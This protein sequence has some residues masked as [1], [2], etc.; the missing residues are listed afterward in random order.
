MDAQLF[1]NQALRWQPVVIK[2]HWVED[3]V[4]VHAVEPGDEV[5]MAV[6]EGMPE[7]QFAGYRGRRSIDRVDRAASFWIKVVNPRLM[8]FSS[9]PVLDLLRVIS[10]W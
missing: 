2:A 1:L 4:P 6:G 9:E 7:M 3:L 8:P 10:F 5:R